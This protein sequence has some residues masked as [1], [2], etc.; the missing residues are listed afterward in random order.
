MGRSETLFQ[1]IYLKIPVNMTYTFSTDISN[2][3]A[4][5][6]ADF[7]STALLSSRSAD[8]GIRNNYSV[9]SITPLKRHL[10]NHFILRPTFLQVFFM[11]MFQQNL[12]ESINYIGF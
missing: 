12:E 6:K 11:L 3:S 5:Q 10:K 4:T 7:R 9:Y 8:C 1:I 2:R